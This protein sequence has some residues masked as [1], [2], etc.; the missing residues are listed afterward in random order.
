MT[1]MLIEAFQELDDDIPCDL[2]SIH[3]VYGDGPAVWALVVKDLPCSCRVNSPILACDGCYQA[4]VAAGLLYCSKGHPEGFKLSS[5]VI[6]VER[7][8]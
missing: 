6:N 4:M 3:E 5:I 8:K 1:E 2:D 7:I